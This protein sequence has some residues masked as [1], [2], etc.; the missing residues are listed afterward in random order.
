[1]AGQF[2]GTGQFDC[3]DGILG[4]TP[5]SLDGPVVA[6]ATATTTKRKGTKPQL[7]GMGYKA[8]SVAGMVLQGIDILKSRPFTAAELGRKVGLSEKDADFHLDWWLSKASAVPD[9]KTRGPVLSYNSST[10]YYTFVRQATPEKP[11]E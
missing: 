8:G 9:R 11:R 10:N 6:P 7:F 1:M 4:P 2:R 3:G 5:G